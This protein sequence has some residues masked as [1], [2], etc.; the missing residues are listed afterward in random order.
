M[1]YLSKKILKLT[2][3]ACLCFAWLAGGQV[4][5]EDLLYRHA[6][7]QRAKVPGLVLTPDGR[8]VNVPEIKQR[9]GF[10]PFNPGDTVAVNV[11][12]L[13]LTL[14]PNQTPFEVLTG[15]RKFAN[16]DLSQQVAAILPN[17][18]VFTV[19]A[20]ISEI[21]A[22]G[23]TVFAGKFNFRLL[24]SS[25]DAGNT[26]NDID[27]DGIADDM[28]NCRL[29]PNSNQADFDNDGEGDVCDEDTLAD[30]DVPLVFQ[31]IPAAAVAFSE[32]NQSC[33]AGD[34]LQRRILVPNQFTVNNLLVGF[35]V[36]HSFRGDVRM[37]LE[38]PSGTRVQLISEDN[39]AFPDNYD[40]YLDDA[41]ALP[42]N[43]GD[44][45]NVSQPFYERDVQPANAL[46]AFNGEPAQ[47]DWVIE[48]CDFFTGDEGVYHGS[49]LIFKTGLDIDNDAT[50]ND[51]DCALL[52]GTRFQNLNG[53]ADIDLDGIGAGAEVSVCS[54][55]AL[56]S[57]FV[58]VGGD[59]CPA[60]PNANQLNTDGDAEGDACDA[61]ID[62]DGVI[63]AND[64]APANP[65]I[66]Q[67]LDGDQCDDCAIGVDGFG[68]LDDFTP[69]NDGPDN[70]SDGLCDIGDP[71]I[72]GDGI[73]NEDDNCPD[74]AN[75]EQDE[76]CSDADELCIPI[77]IDQGVA[78]VCL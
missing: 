19:G 40:I 52:D 67:D 65:N 9:L 61:D 46:S 60:N 68:A 14:Y 37:T 59:N 25:A 71:D 38:S 55:A 54:G 78:L 12:T 17:D 21:N 22:V 77:K 20:T 5:A 30:D 75:P 63:D 44:D 58:T 47:G 35:T 8:Q 11:T 24:V 16:L 1:S 33:Q 72:D 50:V 76:I 39:A 29:L 74:D 45:D 3:C 10:L 69:A 34:S 51:N 7:L 43:D 18:E 36:A 48:V 13:A 56:P 53:F 49:K 70:D 31:D 27:D 2:L 28:D 57:G 26:F 42:A 4:L 66:C 73:L 62:N 41:S 32:L 64:L 6:S 15:E 23:A